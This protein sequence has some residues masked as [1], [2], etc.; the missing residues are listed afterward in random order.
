MLVGE[1]YVTCFLSPMDR[2]RLGLKLVCPRWVS[3]V[4]EELEISGFW[5]S[6]SLLFFFFWLL[7]TQAPGVPRIFPWEH[8]SS[9]SGPE[10]TTRPLPN[11]SGRLVS[12]SLGV[13]QGVPPNTQ[14]ACGWPCKATLG[15]Q[16]RVLHFWPF[17]KSPAATGECYGK[18]TSKSAQ[19]TPDAKFSTKSRVQYSR[20]TS[21]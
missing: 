1:H 17:S 18:G 15:V 8:K 9:L 2:G 4:R 11:N 21:G 5:P 13:P 16:S 7:W 14:V 10:V 20:D 19:T 12:T 3:G 6:Y